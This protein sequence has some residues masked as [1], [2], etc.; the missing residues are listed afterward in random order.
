MKLTEAGLR[1]EGA[2][3]NGFRKLQKRVRAIPRDAVAP[4][5]LLT[6]DHLH[7]MHV[8]Q[9]P[10]YKMILERTY[11]AQRGFGPEFRRLLQLDFRHF[12]AAHGAPVKDDAKDVIGAAVRR[13][14]G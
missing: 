4:P 8:P 7:A 6:G 14:Y 12:I 10:Q 13:V 1:S 11:Y 3:L 5:P 9:G 2:D